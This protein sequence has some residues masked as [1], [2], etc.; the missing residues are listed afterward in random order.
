[1]ETDTETQKEKEKEKMKISTTQL[2]RLIRESLFSEKEIQIKKLIDLVIEPVLSNPGELNFEYALDLA[3][4]AGIDSEFLVRLQT[5]LPYKLSQLESDAIY[6]Q[7]SSIYGEESGKIA[8]EM[9]E[10][11]KI[12]FPELENEIQIELT[13]LHRSR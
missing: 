5:E 8:E 13:N 12:Y 9:Y 4:V 7:D 11:A 10:R 3:R 6:K 1:M 2:Y